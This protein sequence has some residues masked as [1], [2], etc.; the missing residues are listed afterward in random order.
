[1]PAFPACAIM[2]AT[3]APN[4]EETTMSHALNTDANRTLCHDT[5]SRTTDSL[6]RAPA[7]CWC[8]Q[9]VQ[10]AEERPVTLLLLLLKRWPACMGPEALKLGED[11]SPSMLLCLPA[12]VGVLGWTGG[13]P[14]WT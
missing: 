2:T 1:M 8:V 6:D 13:R 9:Q 4:I 11:P 12:E 10:E 7:V 14:G 5:L 3:L